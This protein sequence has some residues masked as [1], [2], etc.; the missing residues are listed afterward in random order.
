MSVMSDPFWNGVS[1]SIEKALGQSF[2]GSSIESTG[3]G[4]INRTVRFGDPAGHSFF[5]KVNDA[6]L[7]PMFETEA[8]GLN[9]I[10][11]TGCIRVPKPVCHGV[12]NEQAFLALEWVDLTSH[13][14]W[15]LMGR[16]LAQLHRYDVGEEY[17]WEQNNFIGATPQ[18]NRQSKDWVEFYVDRRLGEQIRL[19]ESK[20]ARF[21]SWPELKCHLSQLLADHQVR[22][23][24]LHGDLWSGNA[25]FS[26]EGE[27]VIFDVAS[28]LGDRETDLA[29]TRLF[30]GFPEVFYNAYEREW[31][32][33][34]GSRKRIE[35]YNL[36]H[37]L[38]HYNLFGGH[39]VYQA[40]QMIES[41]LGSD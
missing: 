30:G 14:D 21:P 17:G 41:L 32:L 7:L 8:L 19:A 35:L 34:P 15:A 36:Y 23:S 28:Y 1:Q 39:Y 38:N 29:M 2:R 26:L 13:G 22:P 37:I 40:N 20:G 18:I 5:V 11:R 33:E 25:A 3:G 16:Q 10:A 9:Q 12:Y 24:L 27:P 4:C 31:P 6:S